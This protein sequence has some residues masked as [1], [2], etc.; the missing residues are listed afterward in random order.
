[1][2]ARY[3]IYRGK[4]SPDDPQPVGI[5]KD[6]RKHVDHVLSPEPKMVF[7]YLAEPT[8]S[9]WTAFRKGYVQLLE[10]RYRKRREEF[11]A[12][13]DHAAQK[14][15]HIGCSC[16]SRANPNVQRCHTVLALHFMKKKYPKLTV[17]FPESD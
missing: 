7:R 9:A 11:E 1:M 8:D 2:L 17:V 4:R 10:S 13:A 6:T 12:L 15:V 14:D 3:K 5:R 16:P